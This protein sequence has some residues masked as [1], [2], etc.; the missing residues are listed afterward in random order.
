MINPID[1]LAA[2][3][4]KC[5]RGFYK[6]HYDSEYI[7]YWLE[8]KLVVRDYTITST[9]PTTISVRLTEKGRAMIDFH[10]L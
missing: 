8:Y 3:F 2:C 7:K 9:A 10:N 5:S 6:G 4:R 1:I